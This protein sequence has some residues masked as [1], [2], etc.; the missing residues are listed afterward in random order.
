MS[1]IRSLAFAVR[2]CAIYLGMNL[3]VNLGSAVC[4][5]GSPPCRVSPEKSLGSVRLFPLYWLHRFLQWALG[6]HMPAGSQRP[7]VGSQQCIWFLSTLC[8]CV[9][10]SP[11]TRQGHWWDLSLVPEVSWCWAGVYICAMSLPAIDTEVPVS[12]WKWKGWPL[13]Q[14]LAVHASVLLSTA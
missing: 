14:I 4:Y 13:P 8:P 9:W 6:W 10:V 2:G 11:Q 12:N 3:A 1:S 7:M 5:M